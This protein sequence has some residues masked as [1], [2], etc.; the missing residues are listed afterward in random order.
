VLD[1]VSLDLEPV[2]GDVEKLILAEF[3][4]MYI[5]LIEDIKG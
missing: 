3:D 4:A 2:I 5:D 1:S